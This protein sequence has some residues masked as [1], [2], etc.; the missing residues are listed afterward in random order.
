MHSI[1]RIIKKYKLLIINFGYLSIFQFLN[2]LIPLIT[3]PYLIRVLGKET[4]GL[5]I[6]AQAIVAYLVILINFGFNFSATKEISIH[7]NDIDKLNEIVSTVLIVKGILMIFSFLVLLLLI[8]V[9]PQ[10]ITHKYL[11]LFS[12]YACLYDVIFP[13]WYFQGVEK[14]KYI[15]LVNIVARLTFLVLIYLLINSKDDYLLVPIIY[16]IGAIVSGIVSLYIIF[17]KEN[18]RISFQKTEVLLKYTNDSFSYFISNLSIQL[19]VNANKVIVGSFLGLV[20]VAI[21]DLAEK[22]VSVMKIPL[23]IISQTIFPKITKDLDINFVWKMFKYVLLLN[24]LILIGAFITA[25]FL[26][27]FL[28][29]KEMSSATILFRLLI[30]TLPVI[31]MSNFLGIQILIPFGFKKSFTSIIVFSGV[32][33]LLIFLFLYSTKNLSIYTIAIMTILTEI[34]VTAHMYIIIKQKNIL[35]KNTTI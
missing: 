34:Y 35:W 3:Y 9:I 27:E 15:T 31:G 20:E 8:N 5:I 7:R 2:L 26:V 30:F 21:Y 22:L 28:G 1:T 29:G 19:Y 33:F 16:G 13:I 10:A 25:P 4:Y 6:F 12:M 11:F 23:S 32:V 18:I 24:I 17:I 14:M